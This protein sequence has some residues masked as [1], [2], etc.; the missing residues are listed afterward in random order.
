MKKLLLFV[1]LNLLFVAGKTSGQ[2]KELTF[3]GGHTIQFVDSLKVAEDSAFVI[4]DLI[5][6]WSA[7]LSNV[8]YEVG[9]FTH[10][11]ELGQSALHF[12][13]YLGGASFEEGKYIKFPFD[14]GETELR[15]LFTENYNNYKANIT[16][17]LNLKNR[18]YLVASVKG[19][20]S[21]GDY[22]EKYSYWAVN[23]T[24]GNGSVLPKQAS[25]DLANY[26]DKASQLKENNKPA[27]ASKTD[28]NGVFPF[29]LRAE[30]GAG[31]ET[32]F[33]WRG[34]DLAKSPV[35]EPQFN[36]GF[37]KFMLSVKG[38]YALASKIKEKNEFVDFNRIDLGLHYALGTPFGEFTPGITDYYFPYKEIKFLTINNSGSGAHTLELNAAWNGGRFLPFKAFAS[39]NIYND[40]DNSNY[41]EASYIF[42]TGRYGVE[43]FA[44][45]T[46]GPSG[47]YYAKK[48]ALSNLGISV[49]KSYKFSNEVSLPVSVTYYIN[50]YSE[51]NY[52]V[53]KLI[54]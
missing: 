6:G 12:S 41:F 16:C 26:R 52:V 49:S 14:V 4:V 18:Y 30:V 22:Y 47:W 42:K 25:N 40:K 10:K 32:R 53:L 46:K 48:W 3:K 7:Y 13:G 33:F 44:G 35:I 37:E 31:F 11:N 36:I 19:L 27:V 5:K 23:V 28:S 2:T 45:G 24:P 17:L 38:V 54:F 51:E 39:V 21:K 29:S 1:I 8:S 43:V 15:M 20:D 9:V 50:T 34:T